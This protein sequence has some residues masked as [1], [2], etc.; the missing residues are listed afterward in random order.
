MQAREMMILLHLQQIY[1][2]LAIRS[3]LFGWASQSSKWHH[4]TSFPKIW[5]EQIVF[6]EC[7]RSLHRRLRVS[8]PTTEPGIK[9]SLPPSLGLGTQWV[10]RRWCSTPA[11]TSA[12]SVVIGRTI[13]LQKPMK[14][15]AMPHLIPRAPSLQPADHRHVIRLG[16]TAKVALTITVLSPPGTWIRQTQMVPCLLTR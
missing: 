9:I 13:V 4:W 5:P 6:S 8:V 7:P 3:H 16:D 2:H 10:F 12:G 11:A 14:E 15:Y 1:L